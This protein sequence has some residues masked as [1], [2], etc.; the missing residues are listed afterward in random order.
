MPSWLSDPSP[1]LYVTLVIAAIIG[2]GVWFRSQTRNSRLAAIGLA[3]V[4]AVVFV[5]DSAVESPREESV[6]KVAVI[7]DAVN[8]RRPDDLLANVSDSFEYK[9]RTKERLAAVPL[10]DTLRAHNVRVAV[11]DFSRD[12]V[13]SPND[14]TCVVGFMAKGESAGRQVPMY[15][16][17]TFVRDP[18]SQWRVRTFAAYDP[19]QK[20]QGAEISIPG[21]P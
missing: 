8:D 11:W 7:V 13:Q 9:G 12:D 4:L 5:F 15:I 18:D 17:A 21:I 20:A 16:R 3:V 14:T 19:I 10:W 1:T 2:G 6:R